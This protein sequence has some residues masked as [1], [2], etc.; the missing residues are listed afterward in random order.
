MKSIEVRFRVT[1]ENKLRVATKTAIHNKYQTVPNTQKMELWHEI[2]IP[3]REE[4]SVSVDN[5]CVSL[6]DDWECRIFGKNYGDCIDSLCVFHKYLVVDLDKQTTIEFLSPETSQDSV[7][8]LVKRAR[9]N[10]NLNNFLWAFIGALIGI[11]LGVLLK[12]MF[13][14][15]VG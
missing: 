6:M 12:T 14:K 5:T 15:W 8:Q 13:P 4:L 9:R 7:I 3:S 10:R 1:G 2:G 11:A